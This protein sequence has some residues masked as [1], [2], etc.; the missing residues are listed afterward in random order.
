VRVSHGNKV[1]TNLP[2]KVPPG[3]VGGDVKN[4]SW[5]A[6]VT[7]CATTAVVVALGLAILF[8]SVTVAFAVARTVAPGIADQ[9]NNVAV[10]D[11]VARE[12]PS[13]VAENFSG[14]VTDDHC[15]ARHDMGSDM[16]PAQCAKACVHNG[17][18]YVL[19]EGDRSYALEGNSQE[20]GR[21]A[22]LRVTIVGSLEGN[23]IQVNSITAE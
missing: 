6:L 14:L 21:A 19:V 4:R 23:T 16:S 22:G 17:G 10:N 5:F 1:A 12:A 13:T 15:G 9:G 2:Q 18:K 8:A 11:P 20:L 3:S 7:F